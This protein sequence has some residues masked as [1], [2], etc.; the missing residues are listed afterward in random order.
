MRPKDFGLNN[1]VKYYGHIIPPLIQ[2]PNILYSKW[3]TQQMPCCL[4]KLTHPLR[5][6]PSMMQ[7]RMRW[8]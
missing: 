1:F 7:R 2:P 5:G 8:G 3:Y 4:L 6:T